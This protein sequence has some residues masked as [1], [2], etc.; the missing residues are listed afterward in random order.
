MPINFTWMNAFSYI[1][2]WTTSP[3]PLHF[4]LVGRI[5]TCRKCQK[6]QK[7]LSFYFASYERLKQSFDFW[8]MVGFIVEAW[9][10][11]SWSGMILHITYSFLLFS[12][13]HS[14]GDLHSR[15]KTRKMLGVGMVAE[16]GDIH[17]SKV[18]NKGRESRLTFTHRYLI[19]CRSHRCW[20]IMNICI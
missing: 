9:A 6:E 4:V 11:F 3:L 17:R 14:S 10:L 7:S 8:N 13:K 19:F 1:V 18:G 15:L 12:R 5:F 16:D 20:D 2:D